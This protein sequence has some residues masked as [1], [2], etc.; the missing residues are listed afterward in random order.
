[1]NSAIWL[2]ETRLVE[3]GLAPPVQSGT[4]E[5]RMAEP[6][7]ST[8]GLIGFDRPP[9]MTN[10]EGRTRTVGVEIEFAGL[11]AEAAA[12]ALS[13]SFGGGVNQKDPH[14]FMVKNSKLGDI[15]VELELRYVHPD[16]KS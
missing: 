5:T 6:A 13:S 3:P 9:I 1:M 15:A 2:P 7:S 11:T 8:L 16:G 10:A 4:S 14:A 12:K